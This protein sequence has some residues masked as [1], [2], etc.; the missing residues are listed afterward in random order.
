MVESTTWTE[1]VEVMISIYGTAMTVSG[2]RAYNIKHLESF[3]LYPRHK[4]WEEILINI[5][6]GLPKSKEF[7]TMW[8]EVDRLLKMWHVIHRHMTMVASGFAQ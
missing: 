7:N 5:V 2:P 3:Y 6:V 8:V 4:Q 1:C